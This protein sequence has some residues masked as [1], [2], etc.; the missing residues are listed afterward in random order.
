MTPNVLAETRSLN[1]TN[2]TNQTF[3]HYLVFRMALS[4][5]GVCVLIVTMLVVGACIGLLIGH[6][7]FSSSSSSSSPAPTPAGHSYTDEQVTK[8]ILDGIDPEKIKQNLRY[9]NVLN[10]EFEMVNFRPIK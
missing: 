9:M 1:N 7:S 8:M 6:L 2:Q 5:A 10:T 3:P 4:R